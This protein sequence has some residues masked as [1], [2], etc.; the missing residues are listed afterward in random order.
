MT[1]IIK[2]DHIVKTQTLPKAQHN[3]TSRI[4]RRRRRRRKTTT[5]TT[6][7]TTRTKIITTPI[8]QLLVIQF[9]PNSNVN[10]LYQNNSTITKFDLISML[11]CVIT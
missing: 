5:T 7:R 8:S 1:K 9:E 3:Q 2:F 6:V 11:Q 10:M 4:T